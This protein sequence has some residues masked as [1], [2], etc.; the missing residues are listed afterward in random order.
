MCV[1]WSL[2]I[3]SRNNTL[4]NTPQR[5]TL[6]RKRVESEPSGSVWRGRGGRKFPAVRRATL[7]ATE[8][9]ENTGCR[10]E[11]DSITHN[12]HTH[13]HKK[14][15]HTPTY[16]ISH[17]SLSPY[18]FIEML[19]NLKSNFR[20]YQE[21]P[22]SDVQ[23]IGEQCWSVGHVSM[24]GY[25]AETWDV[26]LLH[27]YLYFKKSTHFHPSFTSHLYQTKVEKNIFL[28]IFWCFF[29][30]LFIHI[31]KIHIKV[32]VKTPLSLSDL[33]PSL[34]MLEN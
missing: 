30:D 8:I 1:L 32:W 25:W 23:V 34:L 19:Y 12:I 17:S 18:S 24:S 15:T 11:P 21:Y 9:K 33:H 4:R 28:K 5:Q 10:Q 14:Y 26:L 22:A 7:R 2:S 3:Q 27:H 6:V 20:E 31:F 29:S 13:T 16:C